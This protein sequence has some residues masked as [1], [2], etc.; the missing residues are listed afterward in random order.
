M[1]SGYDR[2]YIG[3]CANSRS[4]YLYRRLSSVFTLVCPSL[5]LK[6]G[7]LLEVGGVLIGP[8]QARCVL[9]CRW[10]VTT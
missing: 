1:T 9:L 6:H 3:A 10:A 7:R 8:F 4:K 2:I 5:N